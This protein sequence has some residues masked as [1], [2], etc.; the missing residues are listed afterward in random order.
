MT[1]EKKSITDRDAVVAAL[2]ATSG[3]DDIYGDESSEDYIQMGSQ[4]VGSDDSHEGAPAAP[5]ASSGDTTP[6]GVEPSPPA[7]ADSEVEQLRARVNSLEGEVSETRRHADYWRA[8][9]QALRQAERH[10]P[11]YQQ[12]EYQHPTGVQN[13]QQYDPGYLAATAY[14]AAQAT[15]QELARIRL[16]SSIA[17]MQTKF[18]A[19]ERE[20]LS[21]NPDFDKHVSPEVRRMAR[22]GMEL[23]I[24][25]GKDLS[26]T[27]YS[28]LF[29]SHYSRSKVQELRAENERLKQTKQQEESQAKELNKLRGIPQGGTY[30]QPM[31]DPA[32]EKAKSKIGSSDYRLSIMDR[33]R[34]LVRRG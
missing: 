17:Q 25:Q 14:E 2:D 6:E 23:A 31:A 22:G 12:P 28:A 15:Q 21:R 19:A 4:D 26:K 13:Y 16:D 8:Q 33:A 27:D 9:E 3:N 5:E 11:Q 29:D 20:F 18:D 24:R 32:K 7:S 1:F 30:Q 10:Q 34:Q